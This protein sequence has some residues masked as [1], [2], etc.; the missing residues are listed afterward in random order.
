MFLLSSLIALAA[1]LSHPTFANAHRGLPDSSGFGYGAKIDPWGWQAELAVRSSA[2]IGLDWISIDLDWQRLWPEREGNI[3]LAELD[4]VM[5]TARQLKLSALIAITSP[6]AWAMTANGP[7]PQLT[8]GLI[9]QLLRLY[10]GTLLAVELFPGANT[11]QGW[12]GPPDP[13]A[14]LKLLQTTHQTIQTIDAH[15]ALI[16]GGFIPITTADRSVAIDDLE[17]LTMLYESGAQPW[18]PIIGIRMPE[19]FGEPIANP[20]GHTSPVMRHYE[21]VRRVMLDHNHTNGLIWITGFSWPTQGRGRGMEKGERVDYPEALRKQQSDWLMQAL[22]L[23]RS[24]L[25][26]GAAFYDCLNPPL[27]LDS[28][29]S[30]EYCLINTNGDTPDFHPAIAMLSEVIAIE[31]KVDKS[32]RQIYLYKKIQSNSFKN[33]AK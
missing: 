29:T 27:H 14:Y 7:D 15:V 3:N 18:M 16:A 28:V 10:Q 23:M 31:H 4:N 17:F 25:Y 32:T 11:S 12:G 8:A 13:Q 9:A 22:Q 33:S 30:S 21:R 19:V 24:Q 2:A 6:P 20:E 5:S 26:I 1:S